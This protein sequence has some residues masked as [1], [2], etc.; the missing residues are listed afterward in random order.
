MR[1]R[2]VLQHSPLY[3][4]SS[5]YYLIIENT[6]RVLFSVLNLDNDSE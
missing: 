2:N 5:E 4:V 1:E 6:A 3:L